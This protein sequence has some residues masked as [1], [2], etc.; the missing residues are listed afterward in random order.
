MKK[1]LFIILAAVLALSSLFVVVYAKNVDN[2]VSAD[3]FEKVLHGDVN[4]DNN[5]NILDITL[6]RRYLAGGYGVELVGDA[7]V[8]NDGAVN[9]LDIALIRRYLAGG[10]GVEL[11]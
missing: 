10:Y 1:I 3:Q 5:I 6:V 11:K 7:D 2:D 4:K 8:N 9:I